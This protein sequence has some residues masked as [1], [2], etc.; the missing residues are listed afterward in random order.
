MRPGHAASNLRLPRT[1]SIPFC[2]KDLVAVI[3]VCSTATPEGRYGVTYTPRWHQPLSQRTDP[4]HTAV[5]PP[6]LDAQRS[7]QIVSFYTGES[8]GVSAD[9]FENSVIHFFNLGD[10]AHAA[11]LTRNSSFPRSRGRCRSAS[12]AVTK[13]GQQLDGCRGNRVAR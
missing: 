5:E 1:R 2:E 8:S 12:A 11:L 9:G 10:D 7:T 6:D 13:M 4:R 3:L